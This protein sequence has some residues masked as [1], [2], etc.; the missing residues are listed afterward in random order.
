METN[1]IYLELPLRFIDGFL[2]GVNFGVEVLHALLVG[3]GHGALMVTQNS[4]STVGTVVGQDLQKPL[5]RM[6][7][8]LLES[9][10]RMSDH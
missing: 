3:L 4:H 9:F 5:H 1:N 7:G 10:C 2:L 6:F 8:C